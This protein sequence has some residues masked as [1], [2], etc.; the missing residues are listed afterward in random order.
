V[1]QSDSIELEKYRIEGE[2]IWDSICTAETKRAKEEISKGKLTYV[3]IKGMVKMYESDAELKSILKKYK[4]E[5]TAQ[6]I[7]C[8][9]PSDKQY[10]YGGLMYEEIKRKFG[11]DF[12]DEKRDE[13]E[14]KYINN[15]INQIFLSS[16][17]DR[18]HS[19]YPLAK[20][21]DDFLE[22]YGKDYFKNFVYPK[23]YIHR[24]KDDLYSWTTVYFILTQ[25]GEITKLKV[26][27]SFRQSY[28][29]KFAKE[30][31]R[32]AKEFV[33]NIQWIPNK[34]RGITVNSQESI[35]FMYDHE[36]WER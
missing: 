23:D 33:K 35:T 9:A 20:D 14:K 22:R 18:N 26:E 16:E 2:K 3:I 12:I 7:F 27:S 29:Q 15:H 25:N 1:S 28:N 34:K 36:D 31:N 30:F 5:T 17:C 19:I 4:I 13:A 8:T 24:K 32:K 6:G 11:E 10:C 21:L